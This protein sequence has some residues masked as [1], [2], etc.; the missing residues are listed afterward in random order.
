MFE[1]V[2]NDVT[3]RYEGKINIYKVNIEDETEIA[4]LFGVRTVPQ[5]SMIRK[6]G[7]TEKEIGAM[8]VDQLKY[9]LEGLTND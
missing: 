4:G 3:P 9:W 7:R 5:V 6:D 1:Q 2:L 8:N